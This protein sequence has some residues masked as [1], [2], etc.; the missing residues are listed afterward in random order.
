MKSCFVI[1][2]F[3]SSRRRHTRFKCDWS[4]DVCSSDLVW[5]LARKR[6]AHVCA[7]AAAVVGV[8]LGA[9]LP[10]GLARVWRQSVEYHTGA[11]PSYP[12]L[13]QLG[14]LLST[15]ATRD[16]VIVAAVVLGLVAASRLGPRSP[17]SSDVRL[18]GIWIA[19]A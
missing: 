17:S 12:P 8:W 11:G 16:A 3:F 7:A 9:A 19:L 10:W 5:L 18:L 2:F 4:S 13:V 1:F 14:R 15:L 6:R